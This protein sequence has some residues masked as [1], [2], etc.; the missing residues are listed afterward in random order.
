MYT[1]NQSDEN[2][3]HRVPPL[4][5]KLKE[6][7]PRILDILTQEEHENLATLRDKLVSAPILAISRSKGYLAHDANAGKKKV[8]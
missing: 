2:F 8:R 6:G 5:T 4:N 7:E 3:G 1:S